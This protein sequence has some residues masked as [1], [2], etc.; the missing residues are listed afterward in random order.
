MSNTD[1]L[2]QNIEDINHLIMNSGLYDALEK[3]YAD[4]AV[5]YEKDM[6]VA[7]SLEANIAREKEFLGG[8][9]EWR[10]AKILHTAA[11]E[12]VTMTEWHLD[13][14]HE[15]YGHKKGN[16]IAVQEWKDGK[17]VREQFYSLY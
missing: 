15:V 11:G 10:E 8:V 2:R 16:Q 6:V 17:V 7:D 9:S 1:T 4:D 13:F 12:N 14:V 5:F 3:Y